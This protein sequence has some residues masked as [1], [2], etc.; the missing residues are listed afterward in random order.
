MRWEGARRP[1]GRPASASTSTSGKRVDVG[2]RCTRVDRFC[3]TTSFS[4]RGT[5]ASLKGLQEH[6]AEARHVGGW[7]ARLVNPLLEH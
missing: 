3:T 4:S 5:H 6:Q 7:G 2:E 1:S